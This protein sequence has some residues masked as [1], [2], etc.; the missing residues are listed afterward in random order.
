MK[1]KFKVKGEELKKKE[2]YYGILVALEAEKEYPLICGHG[3][4]KWLCPKCAHEITQFS[5]F[6]NDVTQVEYFCPICP[7]CSRPIYANSEWTIWKKSKGAF[8]AVHKICEKQ[9]NEA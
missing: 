3:G 4:D 5:E 9:Q 2:N 6:E 1:Y 7:L 8:I